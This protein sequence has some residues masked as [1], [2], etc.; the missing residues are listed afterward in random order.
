MLGFEKYLSEMHTL[1]QDDAATRPLWGDYLV[2]AALFDMGEQVIK[3]MQTLD[4]VYFDTFSGIYG[5]NAY[6]MTRFMTMTNHI[7]SAATP[8]TNGTGGAAGSIGGG[9]FSGGGGGGS[10]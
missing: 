9:G 5:Y 4:P 6:R 7:S 10:R 2:F 8:N 3:R 1:A